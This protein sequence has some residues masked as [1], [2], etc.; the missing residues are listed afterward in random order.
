MAGAPDWPWRRHWFWSLLSLEM[1]YESIQWLV[2]SGSISSF[3]LFEI[4]GWSRSTFTFFVWLNHQIVYWVYYF[5]WFVHIPWNHPA[6]PRQDPRFRIAHRPFSELRE[7]LRGVQ[8][9]PWHLKPWFNFM[10]VGVSQYLDGLYGKFPLTWM[11][12]GY[13]PFLETTKWESLPIYAKMMANFLNW[14]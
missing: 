14:R 3:P 1:W 13:P 11:I 4:G 5:G 6:T 7:E 8:I 12:W 9:A 2:V 10:G